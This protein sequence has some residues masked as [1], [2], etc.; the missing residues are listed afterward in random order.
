[1][2]TVRWLLAI[3]AGAAAATLGQPARAE[4]GARCAGAA[5]CASGETCLTPGSGAVGGE[6][7]AGGMCTKPCTTGPECGTGIC[8]TVDNA[9]TAFC[10]EACTFGPPGTTTFDPGKCHARPEFSCSPLWNDSGISCTGPSDCASG[11]FC[12]GTCYD[13]IP[14]CQPVCNA[15]RDCGPGLYCNPATGYCAAAPR[16]GLEL[17]AACTL[18]GDGATD[19][20]RGSCQGVVDESGASVGNICFEP[21]TNGAPY[22]CGWAGPGTGPAVGYCLYTSSAIVNLA[23]YGDRGSCGAMCDCNSDC[24]NPDSICSPLGNF[25]LEQTLQRRG[26]CLPVAKGPNAPVGITECPEDAG[27]PLDP[28]CVF[29]R[30]KACRGANGCIGSRLCGDGGY[31]DCVCAAGPLDAGT[32]GGADAGTDAGADAGPDAPSDAPPDAPADTSTDGS[33]PA[34]RAVP[35][36]EAGCACAAPSPSAGGRGWLAAAGAALALAFNRRRRS[37]RR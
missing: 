33:D 3:G 14:T 15:D 10:F 17:G 8:V 26:Y 2:K 19:G 36:E 16:T 25:E 23:G 5:E 32:D 34:Q 18:P 20:C 7:P 24:L 9:G 37:A 29:G 4:I 13:L 1:M 35:L 27:A 30:T 31:G 12:Y 6:G 11:Q 28:S 21:C 22:Q